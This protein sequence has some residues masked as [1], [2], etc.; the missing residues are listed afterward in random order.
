MEQPTRQQI[1]EAAAKKLRHD[2]QG[3][4]SVLHAGLRGGEAEDILRTFFR[5]HLPRRYDVASGFIIDQRDRVSKQT[6]VILYDALNCPTYRTSESAAILPANNVAAVVE[7]KSKLDGRGL[8][9]AFEK[10][11][12]VKAL[13]KVRGPE[14]SPLLSQTHGSVFAFDSALSLDSI[15]ERYRQRLQ[16][17][18]IGHHADVICVLDKGLVTLVASIPGEA[19]WGIIFLE[20]LGGPTGEGSHLG[21]G[22]HLLED[23]ALDSFFRLVLAHLTLFRSMVD[24]PGFQWS[25]HLPQG[26]MKLT[27]LTSITHETDPEKRRARLEEYRKRAKEMLSRSP[28]PTDWPGGSTA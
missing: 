17:H 3:L 2:F 26:M 1:F 5:S 28:V 7:V 11:A 14:D 21:V 24:H 12:S 18:G 22:V 27:Y 10:I 23:S 4:T 15:A 20:G 6:D 16:S 25:Q 19:G 13:A 9:D 8:D